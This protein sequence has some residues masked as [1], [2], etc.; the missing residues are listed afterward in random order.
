MISC[1][2]IVL[3]SL[4]MILGIMSAPAKTS[5]KGSAVDALSEQPM[6]GITVSA[7]PLSDIESH[8]KILNSQ[9]DRD[10]QYEIS[11]LVPDIHYE[12]LSTGEGYQS[13]LL[14]AASPPQGETRLL[15]PMHVIRGYTAD[16]MY[17]EDLNGRPVLLDESHYHPVRKADFLL[18]KYINPITTPWFY[19][20]ETEF[21]FSGITST[22]R[23]ATNL[24]KA[25]IPGDY[26]KEWEVAKRGE[27]SS[28][29]SVYR[30][31]AGHL[32]N[33]KGNFS[34]R[35]AD[36]HPGTIVT[37]CL[38]DES[39]E[40]SRAKALNS[41][42]MLWNTYA[43]GDKVQFN[44][45]FSR[46]LQD[47]YG[48][49]YQHFDQQIMHLKSRGLFPE[50]Y[51]I[52]PASVIY[53]DQT[54][55]IVGYY[56]IESPEAV[57][58]KSMEFDRD[59]K[60]CKLNFDQYAESPE[61]KLPRILSKTFESTEDWWTGDTEH[62]NF[63]IDQGVYRITSRS[64]GYINQY[65]RHMISKSVIDTTVRLTPEKA[66]DDKFFA[67]VMLRKNMGDDDA[68]MFLINSNRDFL[69]TDNPK[70]GRS[71]LASGHFHAINPGGP[72][73]L[74]I[75]VDGNAYHCWINGEPVGTWTHKISRHSGIYG[76]YCLGKGTAIFDDFSVR[77]DV[78]K[79][80]TFGQS[81]WKQDFE[82]DV[83][84]FTGAAGDEYADWRIENG[85]LAGKTLKRSSGAF[86][87]DR[88]T[89]EDFYYSADIIIPENGYEASGIAFRCLDNQCGI[90][91]LNEERAHLSLV[92]QMGKS[93]TKLRE[94]RFADFHK[95]SDN[96]YRLGVLVQGNLFHAFLDDT[97]MFSFE[98]D[99][100]QGG[101]VGLYMES[102][103]R[104]AD[105]LR[106]FDNIE[107][108]K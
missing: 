21:Q 59:G 102:D 98:D 82:S 52:R 77:A 11:G 72:N 51:G 36:I 35:R 10:G 75:E 19:T 74:H 95:K 90:L 69:L 84:V 60:V 62:A 27:L 91:R 14:K 87:D 33:R 73:A 56:F 68:Y 18:V 103:V 89:H 5:F 67:G 2:M 66:R 79:P 61:S 97:Y 93:K 46:A 105:S 12:I 71:H 34:I 6:A 41:L 88:G 94:I 25:S 55:R 81:V 37:F 30:F 1:R 80:E 39:L 50:Q 24:T 23:F 8:Q 83:K 92:R 15:Q 78:F 42:N 22:E 106:Y 31:R 26:A 96:I 53:E 40:Q 76:L 38:T 43:G 70:S 48:D 44:S 63:S 4:A 101:A 85:R 65:N 28:G 64:Y 54:P 45:L 29:A 16:G 104:K 3:T 17:G 32:E 107:L 99:K 20:Y 49:P 7:K 86:I 58:M 47:E 108:R 9:T 13:L 100:L 57:T